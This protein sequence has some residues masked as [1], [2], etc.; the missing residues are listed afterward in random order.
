MIAG[1][2]V[3]IPYKAFFFRT[4][5]FILQKEINRRH[6]FLAFFMLHYNIYHLKM[7]EKS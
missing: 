2:W 4:N 6:D 3:R 5:S 1:S 7:D